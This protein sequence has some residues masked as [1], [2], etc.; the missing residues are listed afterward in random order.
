[1]LKPG[2]TAA[3]MG[4]IDAPILVIGLAL[5]IAI[6]ASHAQDQNTKKARSTGGPQ[7]QFT[8]GGTERCV[9]CHSGERITDIANTVHGNLENPHTPYAQQGC[10]SC[11]GPGSLHA[12]R[13]RGGRGFPPLLS[14]REGEPVQP[15]TEAC[16]GCHGKQMG[17]LEAMQWS[18]SLHAT[19][20]MTCITC[21]TLHIQG[22]PLQ[23]REFQQELCAECH[24]RQVRTHRRFD[25]VG[26]EFD[27]LTCYECHDV[28]QLIPEQ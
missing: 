2:K 14:F 7:A 26:I 27:E 6:A 10:E 18:G 3:R 28:H 13:A 23:D 1:M 19:D 5:L 16:I 24:K 21:H 4:R 17:S 20:D 9:R 25:K 15:Q 11:H 12:S 8:A 22:N